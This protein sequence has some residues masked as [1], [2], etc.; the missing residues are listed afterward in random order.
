NLNIR[1]ISDILSRLSFRDFFRLSTL[2]KDWK[3]ICWRIPNVKFDETVWKTPEDLTSPTIGFIPN[4]D[5][6]LR[7]PN[8]FFNCYAFRHL[9]LKECEIQLPCFF[10]EF[11]NLI[12][13]ILKFVI[14]SSDT[15]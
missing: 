2:S 6:F 8:F 13:L 1:L 5:S 11:N 3:Y 7:L 4:I 9:Y 15:F 14:L 12:R 10:K